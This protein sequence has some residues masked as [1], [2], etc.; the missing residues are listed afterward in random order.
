MSVDPVFRAIERHRK[1]YAARNAALD[2]SASNSRKAYAL[3]GRRTR[4]LFARAD[5]LVRV[6]PTTL[7]GA[8]ALARYVVGHWD[9]WE[10]EPERYFEVVARLA[11]AL[12]RLGA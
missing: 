4:S 8:T 11:N 10:D 7:K 6:E 12:E 3:T 1:A 9:E 2:I 5:E